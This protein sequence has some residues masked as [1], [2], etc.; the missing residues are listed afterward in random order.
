[1]LI[2]TLTE[3]RT[4]LEHALATFRELRSYKEPGTPPHLALSGHEADAI[5]HIDSIN[6]QIAACEK[7]ARVCREYRAKP[8]RATFDALRSSY[9]ELMVRQEHP[10]I[11]RLVP[12]R[13]APAPRTGCR[14]CAH[15]LLTELER[16]LQ[17]RYEL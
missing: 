12:R 15:T 14:A 17:S 6:A 5:G 1:M 10:L 4:R 9:E 3:E 16:A 2:D 13:P 7:A 8:C 11:D